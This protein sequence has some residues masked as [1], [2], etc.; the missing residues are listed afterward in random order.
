MFTKLTS[1]MT[2]SNNRVWDAWLTFLD[3]D[4][5]SV[6]CFLHRSLVVEDLVSNHVL[7]RVAFIIT[8]STACFILYTRSAG[9]V[10]FATGAVFCCLSV[11]VI[12]EIIRQPRP[13]NR[14][15]LKV[16]YGCVEQGLYTGVTR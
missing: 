6:L 2:R 7:K 10:Y 14:K 15:K 8:A 9:V 1:L 13:P 5:V 12:K 16:S 4:K 11:K 3:H